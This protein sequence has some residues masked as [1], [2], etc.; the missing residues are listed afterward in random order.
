MSVLYDDK[1]K[2]YYCKFRY[3]DYTGK[4]RTTTKRGFARKK[5]A[6]RY[7]MEFKATAK[8]TP[9]IT[10]KALSA[11]FLADAKQRVR[12]NSYRSFEAICRLHIVPSLGDLKLKKVTP[13]IINKWQND[14]PS[15]VSPQTIATWR[16]VCCLMFNHAVRYLGLPSNPF[17]NVPGRGHQVQRLK[18]WELEDFLS[19]LEC[20]HDTTIPYKLFFSVLFYSGMR[21][22]EF[23]GL[24]REDIDF[25]TN[26]ISVHRTYNDRYMTVNPP[27][28]KSSERSITMPQAIMNDIKQYLDS[29]PEKTEYPFAIVCSSAISRALKKAARLAGVEPINLHGLRHSH[30]SYLLHAGVSVT[31]VAHRLGHKSSNTTLSFYAHF[32]E[33]DD[34]KIADMLQGEITKK[35]ARKKPKIIR[36]TFH[37]KTAKNDPK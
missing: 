5:D 6:L 9:D 2:T 16:T 37:S 21:I 34:N 1:R 19:V 35:S 4:Q 29:I 8:E 15:D 11:L 30:T 20:T 28:T 32:Y 36:R 17:T 25:A 7:E 14:L 3:K 22:G 31:D 12:E 24:M 27:K 23:Q 26:K 10:V 13:L 33:N 18:F